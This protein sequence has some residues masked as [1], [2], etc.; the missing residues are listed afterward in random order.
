MCFVFNARV[1]YNKG[2]GA[3]VLA[4]MICVTA[5]AKTDWL[6]RD[7]RGIPVVLIINVGGINNLRMTG[8]GQV[9]GL[10][11][12]KFCSLAANTALIFLCI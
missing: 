7:C 8:C 2:L 10:L 5:T 11:S 12:E 9:I 1:T 4:Y 6:F 3:I